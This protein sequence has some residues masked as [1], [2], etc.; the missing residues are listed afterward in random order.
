MRLGSLIGWSVVY[1]LLAASATGSTQ[2]ACALPTGLG[3]EIALKFPGTRIVTLADLDDFDRKLYGKDHGRRCPGLASVDFYGDHK[4]TSAMVLISGQNPKRKAELIVA[5]QM[6]SD[7][8]IRSLSITDG[9]PVVWRERPGKYEGMYENQT[10]QAKNPV[11]VFC[12]YGSWEIVFAWT[13]KGLEKVWLS[14]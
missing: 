2:E 8:E 5:H 14:D 1:L 12:G 3:D 6:N 11:I 13:D 4:P 10:V 7:W 9:T